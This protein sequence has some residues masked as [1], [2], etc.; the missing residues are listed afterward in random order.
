[1]AYTLAGV[2]GFYNQTAE[3]QQVEITYQESDQLDASLFVT[4]TEIPT[5]EPTIEPT[6]P[7]DSP[8]PAGTPVSAGTPVGGAPPAATPESGATL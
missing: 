3:V 6:A 7:M 5:L 8:V 1:M 4:P 2:I